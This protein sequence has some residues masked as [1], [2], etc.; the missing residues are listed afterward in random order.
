MA[1]PLLPTPPIPFGTNLFYIE[2][3]S[4]TFD[5]SSRTFDVLPPEFDVNF[6]AFDVISTTFDSIR[7]EAYSISIDAYSILPN[8]ASIPSEAANK[9]SESASSEITADVKGGI[10]QIARNNRIVLGEKAYFF[11]VKAK[12]SQHD[13]E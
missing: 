5:V 2:L 4:K 7:A 3:S 12:H 1:Y 13:D 8:A 10:R 9:I 6:V 11:D